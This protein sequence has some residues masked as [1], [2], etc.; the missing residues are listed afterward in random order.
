MKK[1]ASA[2]GKII[3]SGEYAVVFGYPGV[4]TPVSL[5]IDVAWEE[6]TSGG[7]E[8]LLNERSER[9]G[10]RSYVEKILYCLGK[11]HGI[12]KLQS[13]LPIGRGMGSSTALVI[14][15]ARSILGE[16]CKEEALK[17]EDAVNPEHSGLDFVV[18]WSEKPVLFRKG[19]A[20]EHIQIPKD[21]LKGA[22]LI[23]TG[24]PNEATPELVA[25]VKS[26][27]EELTESIKEIG[28]C[29]EKLIQGEDFPSIVRAHHQAQV[30]IGVVP[31]AARGL[32]EEIE[33]NGGA[34]KVLGA[35]GRTGGGG[36]VLTL[37]ISPEALE[38]I[39]KKHTMPFFPL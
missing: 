29:T 2:C 38:V 18:I 5:G 31:V 30:H 11:K 25:W 14:A 32:I 37:N 6:K 12:L 13:T 20:P 35:G 8:I 36:M 17:I 19:S 27:K 28:Q 7:V 15:I 34:A 21:L 22:F 24:K 9:D 3:L 16:N 10:T 1:S 33:E 4:A 26:R 23:D 39:A